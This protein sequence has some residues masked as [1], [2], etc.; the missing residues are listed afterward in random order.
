M[1]MV[2]ASDGIY[3]NGTLAWVNP[4][5]GFYR[6]CNPRHMVDSCGCSSLWVN[7]ELVYREQQGIVFLP[8]YN[9]NKLLYLIVIIAFLTGLILRLV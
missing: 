5:P 9:H 1:S 8:S 6:S 4:T 7:G 2:M 3:I